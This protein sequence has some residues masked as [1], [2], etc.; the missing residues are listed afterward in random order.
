LA[1]LS[2]L[3]AQAVSAA[4]W[5]FFSSVQADARLRPSYGGEVRI[6]SSEAEPPDFVK[7]LVTDTLTYVDARGEVRPALAVR[8]ETQNGGRRWQFWLRPGV[9][10]HGT[11]TD[12]PLTSATVADAVRAGL[13]KAGMEAR[14]HASGD[15]LTV[16]FE[17][18]A[19]QFAAL[20]SGEQ[21]GVG[22]TD[23]RGVTVGSGPYAIQ[24]VVG[25]RITLV[26]NPDYWGRRRFPETITVLCGRTPREQVLDLAAKRADLV[27]VPAEELRH[28]QQERT[29]LSQI[30]AT[31]LVVLSA[32]RARASDA[33]LRQALSESIDRPALLN[34]IFQKQG[35][36][37]GALLPNWISGYGALLPA[38]HDAAHARQLRTEAGGRT[39]FTVG[40]EADDAALQLLAER[41]ALNAR[42]A[43]LTVRA[44]AH[45]P[46][47]DWRLCRV[48]VRTA[49]PA[50]ALTEVLHAL[51]TPLEL[52][53]ASLES[54]FRAERAALADYTELPLVHLNR[55]WAASEHLRDW[56]NASPLSPL[57]AESW[58]ESKP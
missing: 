21:F 40:Y 19:P 51:H 45:A 2:S 23:A 58:V 36:A 3:R 27:E 47:V 14:L 5:L 16:E 38:V 41:I 35:E 28:A 46:E 8:W 11:E 43:G 30:Q 29:R 37:S 17:A 12:V 32:E 9:Q 53:D 54:V 44:V 57:P 10:L 55:A 26:A 56:G 31:E 7:L 18:P 39:A 48:P 33:K 49:N 22:T 24:S 52:N 25:P 13:A 1:A 4:L 20:L 6:E 42:E 15:V 34:F 50:A